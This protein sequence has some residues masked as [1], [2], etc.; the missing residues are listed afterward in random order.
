LTGLLGDSPQR[1][2]SHKLQ[3]FNSFAAPELRQAIGSLALKPGMRVLDAGCGTGDSLR[4]LHDAVE[5]EGLVV[6]M[7]LAI[8]HTTAARS[9]APAD[10]L[11]LQADLLKVPLQPANFDLVWCVNTINHLHDPVAGLSALAGLLRRRGRIA[12]GQTGLLPDMYF[13]WD[14]RLERAVNEA[15][16]EYYRDRYR[17]NEHELT[18]IRALV[19]LLQR[20]KLSNIQ[21]RTFVIERIAPLHEADERYLLETIFQGTW[22]ARLQPYLSSPDFQQLT[23]LCNPEHPEFALRRPDFHFLQTFTVATGEI[24]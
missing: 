24:I 14:S 4:W 2:Y 13:A 8:A 12:L 1:D 5:A 10:A 6:G 18:G 16:R 17:V 22:G 7:D 15:V 11:V 21:V 9:R 3:S 19:G 23:R 20:A